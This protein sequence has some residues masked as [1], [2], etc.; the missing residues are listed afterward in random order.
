MK[1][2]SSLALTDLSYRLQS[3]FNK[4]SS[5]TFKKLLLAPRGFLIRRV[6]V[7]NNRLIRN[8]QDAILQSVILMKK[9]LYKLLSF[10]S[11]RDK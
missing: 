5:I 7:L 11:D 1:Y 8:F 4:L 3:F 6:L 2:L 9:W 10:S